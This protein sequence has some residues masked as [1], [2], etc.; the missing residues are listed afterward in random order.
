MRVYELA[1]EAGVASA[2][3]LKAA[4]SCGADVTSAISTIDADELPA[5]KAAVAGLPKGGDLE[6]K[7]ASKRAR[8]EAM[9]REKASADNDVLAAHL[10]AAKAAYEGRAFTPVASPK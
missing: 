7:R 2:D 4:E 6:A 9:R 10:E 1:R 8:A 5:L 3:V